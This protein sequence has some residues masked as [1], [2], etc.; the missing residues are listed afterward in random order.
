MGLSSSESALDKRSDI[1]ESMN[2]LEA[3][4][5]AAWRGNAMRPDC[6]RPP[7]AGTR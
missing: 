6:M 2:Q 7:G 5:A 3:F 4:F 1:D